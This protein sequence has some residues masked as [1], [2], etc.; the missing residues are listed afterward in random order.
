MTIKLGSLRGSWCQ[1]VTVLQLAWQI[2][3]FV[4]QGSFYMKGNAKLDNF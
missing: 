2:D 1:V 3:D 4:L